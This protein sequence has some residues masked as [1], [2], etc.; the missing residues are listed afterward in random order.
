[1][2][3]RTLILSAD[4]GTSAMKMG[5]FDARS[6]ALDLVAGFQQGYEARTYEDGLWSDIDP[7]LWVQAF[8]AGTRA[9]SG[10]LAD[11][12]AIALSGTTPG[13]TGI[14]DAGAAVHP[15][16]LML[17][18]RSRSQAAGIIRRAGLDRLL[19]E[20]GNMPVP[21]GCSL[22]SILWLREARPEAYARCRWLVHSNG[23]L[24]AWLT[25]EPAMDPS[26][27]SLS[28]LYST[29]RAPL[30]WNTDLAE[31]FGVSLR[32]LP[33][34]LPSSG[35]PGRIRPEV[36]RRLGLA[37]RPPVVIGGNDA[38][39]A[40]HSLGVREPGEVVNVNGTCEI[41][42][43]CLD[44]CRASPT[45]NVRCH[46]VPGRWLTLYVMNAQGK[47]YEWL[48]SVVC[49]EMPPERF[50]DEFLPAAVERWID[51]RSGVEYVPYLMG[52]RYTLDP[53]CGEFR[54]LTPT[55]GREELAA[56]MVRGLCAYQ[57]AH[58][59]ELGRLLPLD[60]VTRVAGG[61][62]SP[63]LIRAKQVWMRP[64]EYVRGEESSLRGAAMLA[65]EHLERGNRSS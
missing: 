61:A 14:D 46:V 63:A 50:Y 49:S 13:L 30:G 15:A 9:L 42:L 40:A 51:R 36:A 44:S 57:R 4:I 32:L 58:L 39:L 48:R 52:S 37:R 64:G 19:R 38:V 56:A 1:M 31:L 21:G 45:Y 65:R 20:T 26:S 6:P 23:F 55:V 59:E 2:P 10:H 53:L 27:A 5:V 8:E 12:A 16:I 29:P 28:G 43:V 33:P 54:G 17:D 47:A 24:S 41:T 7:T 18:Q 35:S 3:E 60:P 22:A 25:G 62:V 34:I 11:V